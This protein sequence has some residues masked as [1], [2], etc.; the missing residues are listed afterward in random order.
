[1]PPT[2]VQIASRSRLKTLSRLLIMGLLLPGCGLTSPGD[3]QTQPSRSK[4]Q[5]A[6]VDVA[7][8]K[9]T[10]LKYVEPST[11]TTLPYR[12]V[13]VRSQVAGQVLDIPVDVGNPVRRGQVLAR[14]DDSLLESAV[15]EADAEVAARQ[16]EVASLQAE[17]EEAQ[18]L[19]RQA[20][21]ELQQARSDADRSAQLFGQGAIS[22]QQAE[23]DRT[24]A[25]TA[26]QAVRSAQQQ[27]RTRQRAV[28]ASQRRVGSQ[29]AL[30]AQ[31]QQRQAYTVLTASVGGAVLERLLEPGD[32]AAVGTEILKLGDLSQIKVN[33]RVS[34]KRLANIR[35]GQL[36]QV[37]L[38]AFPNQSFTGRV[39]QISPVV[40]LSAPIEVTI[41][42][43]E[44][45]I[46]AGLF[47]RVSFDPQTSKRVVNP[48]TAIQTAGTRK[49]KSATQP[50]KS[51]PSASSTPDAQPKSATIFVIKE[52]DRAT[53]EAR[54]V[55][56]GDRSDQQV[57]VL[58]GLEPGEKFVV[59]S[60]GDL[61]DGASVRVS[62]ISE[63]SKSE[64]SKQ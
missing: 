28:E 52:G 32:V 17:V 37:K 3:A 12:E 21:L 1:M 51:P 61:K 8:A 23:S 34:D 4:Q 53:V 22:E 64:N 19:V 9:K 45:K 58:S 54:T 15:I 40:G 6:A 50:A 35:V 38:D 33:V 42:N 47:A 46:G 7:I 10:Q 30:V 27:V 48:E 13:S 29:E 25:N 31:A 18:T 39:S 60:T 55:K 62:F 20:Q 63:N 44:G 57:E 5:T 16:S 2:P 24:A 49:D 59:R 36:A 41:P 14:L 11:G 56:L 26:V 43:S